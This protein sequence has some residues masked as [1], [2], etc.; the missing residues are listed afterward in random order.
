[1]WEF[2]PPWSN[3]RMTKAQIRKYLK[4]MKEAKRLAEEK[5]KE[6]QNSWELDK[7]KKE[8]EELEKELDNL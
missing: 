4:D 2:A 5:L 8:I 6:A 1:M 7:E 3:A